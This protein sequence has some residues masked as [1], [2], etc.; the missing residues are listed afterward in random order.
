THKHPH[1]LLDSVVK[2]RLA[3]A[4]ASTEA[5]ILQHPH[6]L[7]SCFSKN[8]SFFSTPCSARPD[9][10]L[11]SGRRILQRYKPLSTP[12]FTAFDQPDRTINSATQT[13]LS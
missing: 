8:F 1:E 12:S 13:T 11:S 6:L 9:H 2:E 4:F 3:E 7:S 10:L 5:R